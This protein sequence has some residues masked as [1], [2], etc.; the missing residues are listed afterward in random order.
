MSSES[1]QSST[2]GIPLILTIL[3]LLLSGCSGTLNQQVEGAEVK[4]AK[5]D[6]EYVYEANVSEFVSNYRQMRR[7]RFTN[8]IGFTPDEILMQRE[9]AIDNQIRKEIRRLPGVHI[10]TAEKSELADQM[11]EEL[12]NE[13]YDAILAG[14]DFSQLARAY[15]DSPTAREGGVLQPF[16]ILDNP[17]PYQERAYTMEIGEFTE[18][19]HSWDGWRIIKVNDITDDPLSGIFYYISMIV[20]VPDTPAAE[21]RI[22]DRIA[23]GHTIEILDPKYNSRRALRDGDFTE[24]LAR[25]DEAVS[26]N[27]DDDLAHYLRARAL[28]EL[29]RTD[30]A[31]DTL[32]TAAEVGTI[33]DGF[34][35]YYHF[36]RGEYLE[37]LDRSDDALA[38]Y[39]QSYDT[40][41]Q[42]INLAFRLRDTFGRL[43]DE[44]Y[45][46]IMLGEIDDIGRQDALAITF[47]SG[48]SSASGSVIITDQGQAD[49][50]SVEY[51]EGYRE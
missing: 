41:Q 20:L 35:P 3:I 9:L 36:Y 26:R 28:W 42:N 32:L 40:W 38:A 45:M 30:E 21:A 48:P 12:V 31:L 13:V 25:A 7:T 34:I 49:S 39:H 29:D 44:E 18:P 19:F 17:E 10:T 11:V 51:E 6:T 1:Y 4:L 15:S 22:L 37:E 2:I 33:S 27:N 5:V 23:E 14:G 50:T 46:N 43:G 24:A 47:G 16:G 8:F